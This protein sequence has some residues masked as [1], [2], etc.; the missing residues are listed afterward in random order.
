MSEVQIIKVIVSNL[1]PSPT[2]TAS[3]IPD[4]ELRP[5]KLRLQAIGKN[6]HHPLAPVC[7][8]VYIYI[9]IISTGAYVYIYIYIYAGV[10]TY[11]QYAGMQAIGNDMHQP[12][13]PIY[14]YTHMF[15]FMYVFS[16]LVCMP[17]LE[18]SI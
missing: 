13:A 5:S 17:R 16:M 14:I 1:K 10:Y 6:M 11:F 9:Y 18:C 8:C 2:A 3:H 4:R 15:E 12:H 7:V